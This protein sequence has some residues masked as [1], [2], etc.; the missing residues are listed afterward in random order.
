MTSSTWG[1][2]SERWS[3]LYGV[4]FLQYVFYKV[5]SNIFD[6]MKKLESICLH[7]NRVLHLFLLLK[8]LFHL[9]IW[10]EDIESFLKLSSIAFSSTKFFAK[11]FSAF[12]R[13]A[14]S[15]TSSFIWFLKSKRIEAFVMFVPSRKICSRLLT[16]HRSL[17]KDAEMPTSVTFVLKLTSNIFSLK[18]K[19]FVTKKETLK[20]FI[21]IWL[22]LL[23]VDY[24]RMHSYQV[25]G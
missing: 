12:P 13:W 10:L 5:I 8:A 9:S 4:E 16:T 6:S 1:Q 23:L 14:D 20:Q 18:K 25:K 15:T 21:L 3:K 7:F 17:S 19:H 22:L 2:S 11:F 24:L